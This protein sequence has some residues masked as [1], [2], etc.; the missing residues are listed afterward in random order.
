MRMNICSFSAIETLVLFGPNNVIQ[1]EGRNTVT[2]K[3]EDVDD[4]VL[5]EDDN[6]LF[7][8][9]TEISSRK[10]LNGE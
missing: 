9:T 2:E 8:I 5:T 7:V 1:K 4:I 10:I 6:I 3:I